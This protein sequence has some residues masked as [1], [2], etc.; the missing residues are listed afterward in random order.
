MGIEFQPVD[1]ELLRTG[2]NTRV[3]SDDIGVSEVLAA[4][5]ER[6]VLSWVDSASSTPRTCCSIT[7]A[8][9]DWRE[10]DLLSLAQ[11]PPVGGAFS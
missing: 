11:F 6:A 9:L 2:G 8:L 1:I 10:L 7:T 4:S 5:G 3:E